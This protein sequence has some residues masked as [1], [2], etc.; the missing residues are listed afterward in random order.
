[1]CK[2]NEYKRMTRR[3]LRQLKMSNYP[4]RAIILHYIITARFKPVVNYLLHSM[5]YL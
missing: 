3:M 2:Y 4:H 5:Q 1:M